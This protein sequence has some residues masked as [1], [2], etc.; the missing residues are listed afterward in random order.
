MSREG[1]GEASV[2]HKLEIQDLSYWYRFDQ[3][4][5]RHVSFGIPVR[6][7]TVVFGPA[8]AGKTTLLRLLNR[9][10]DRVY[11]TR[12]EGRIL[13]DGE[14]IYSSA[15][16]VTRLRRRV[17]MVFARPNPLP[18]TV[19]GNVTYG[20]RIS[21]MRDRKRLEA[22]LE[23]SLRRAAMWDEVKDRLDDSAEDLS[24]GQKQRLCVARALAL[25]PEV[26]L[27]NNPTAA[28]DPISTAKIEETLQELS[29]TMSI[30]MS[31]AS[32]QQAGRMADTAVFMLMGEVIEVAPGPTMFARP[33]DKRTEDYVTGRFG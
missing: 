24:G 18:G 4:A 9:L 5:L 10:N 29:R 20:L 14:D 15:M 28:L 22:L 12:M 8:G 6:A 1:R 7:V 17:G 3:P 31:P 19:R 25:E 32:I 33:Q 21:G 16:D 27:L 11:D 23:Q 30:V 13:L 26:L 2:Q